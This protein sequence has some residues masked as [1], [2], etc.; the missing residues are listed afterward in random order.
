MFSEKFSAKKFNKKLSVRDFFNKKL[1]V[2][3]LSKNF[4]ERE[5][6]REVSEAY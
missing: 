1:G 5:R 4:A 2:K 6:E 3:M